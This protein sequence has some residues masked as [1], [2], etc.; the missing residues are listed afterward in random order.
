MLPSRKA[1]RCF[2][3]GGSALFRNAVADAVKGTA[4]APGGRRP[5]YSLRMLNED[6]LPHMEAA[7]KMP[8]P[9]ESGSQ[10]HYIAA[11][12]LEPVNSCLYKPNY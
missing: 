11:M 1:Q 7:K 3:A 6:R 10:N 2:M 5:Q 8:P 9:H 4:K 12:I